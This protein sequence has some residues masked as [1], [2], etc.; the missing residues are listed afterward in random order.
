VLLV[1]APTTSA[2]SATITA[3]GLIVS[4]AIT[5]VITWMST[6]SS[7]ASDAKREMELINDQAAYWKTYS[8]IFRD[9]ASVQDRAKRAMLSLCDRTESVSSQD[10][11]QK[12]MQLISASADVQV[13]LWRFIFHFYGPARE[14]AVMYVYGLFIGGTVFLLAGYAH[15]IVNRI[16]LWIWIFNSGGIGFLTGRG[17]AAIL[18]LHHLRHLL[19]P[20]SQS[21]GN[22]DCK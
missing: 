8:E 14:I 3:L 1:D 9:D 16:L 11:P 20:G 10:D 17:L 5:A 12:T 19:R 7:T 13:P 2:G 22:K 4:T 15:Q 21:R 18:D 6:R